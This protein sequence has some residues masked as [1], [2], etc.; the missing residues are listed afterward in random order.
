MPLSQAHKERAKRI[1]RKNRPSPVVI[2]IEECMSLGMAVE[3][4]AHS[5]GM[6]HIE[7]RDAMRSA[8]TY[9]DN[10]YSMEKPDNFDIGMA[11]LR[12]KAAFMRGSLTEIRDNGNAANKER[13]MNNVVNQGLQRVEVPNDD[14]A[15]LMTSW[16]SKQEVWKAEDEDV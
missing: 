7:L 12:G 14:G 10:K 11:A 13:V 3:E 9:L 4:A 1:R 15:K 6:G 5:V 2:D 16:R 8:A